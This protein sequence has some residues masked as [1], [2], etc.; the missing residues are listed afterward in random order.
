[1]AHINFNDKFM[2]CLSYDVVS[3]ILK[4]DLGLNTGN[5]T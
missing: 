2:T 3:A 5:K 1:M 4:L